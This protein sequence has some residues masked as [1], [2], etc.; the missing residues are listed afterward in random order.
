MGADVLGVPEVPRRSLPLLIKLEL[1]LYA[2]IT[3][4]RGDLGV[5]HQ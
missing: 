2:D 4:L 5:L 3:E 1:I